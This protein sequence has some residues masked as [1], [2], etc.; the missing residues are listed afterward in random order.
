LCGLNEGH[1]ISAVHSEL[2]ATVLD[3]V[4]ELTFFVRLVDSFTGLEF[5]CRHF[6]SELDEQRLVFLAEEVHPFEFF[7]EGLV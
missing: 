4:K 3:Q 1:R 2:Y 6:L 7:E 5:G